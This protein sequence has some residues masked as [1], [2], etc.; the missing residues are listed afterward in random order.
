MSKFSIYTIFL[1]I[2][3]I[4][5]VYPFSKPSNDFASK[6]ALEA[7]KAFDFWNYMRSY[8]SGI[9]RND[10]WEK[11]FYDNKNSESTSRLSANW[12]AIGPKNIG[13]RTLC[14][15]VHPLDSNIIY[16][17]SASGGLWKSTSGG[18]GAQ[19]W[20]YVPTG[21]PVLGVASI[22]INPQNPNEM[23][24]GTGEV[25]NLEN[26]T[27]NIVFRTTRGSYGIGILK[28]NDGGNTW[29][30]VLDWSS[31][32]M[33]GV[34]DLII[35]PSNPSTIYAAT[36]NGLYKSTNSGNSWNLI[37]D[38]L[39][40]VDLLLSPQDTN[41]I[42]VTHGSLDN[43][44]ESGI[45]KSTNGGVNF[46]KLNTGVISF[47][48]KAKL[49]V[50]L[51][52]PTTIYA[53]IA[54]AFVVQGLY[55]S[56]DN[57]VTWFAISTLNI[58]SYQGWYSHDVAISHDGSDI[59]W[60]GIDV[61]KS[62]SDLIDFNQSSYWFGW[63]IDQTPLAGED[64]GEDD[65]VHSD[66]HQI[67][68]DNNNPNKIYFATDGGLFI[69]YDN[70]LTFK[71]RNGGY[72]TQQFY[73]KFSNSSQDPSLSIGGMQDNATA[74]YTGNLSWRRLI[75]GDGASTFI[76]PENDFNIYA[77]TQYG[78]I[79]KSYDRG[80]SFFDQ[81]NVPTAGNET[82]AF[83]APYT[84]S[85]NIPHTFYFGARKI[86]HSIDNGNSW[87]ESTLFFA[88]N[89]VAACIEVSPNNSN[90]LYVSTCSEDYTHPPKI[91]KSDDFGVN[92]QEVTGLPDRVAMDIAI[93]PETDDIAYIVFGGFGTQHLYKTENQGQTWQ[94]I[95]QGLPDVPTY[96][97]LIDPLYPNIIYVGNEIGV[98][99]SI[100]EGNTF[101][102]YDGYTPDALLAMDLTIT[103]DRKLRLATY[104]NG[105]W[106]ADMI[107]SPN[108][109]GENEK[110]DFN[111]YPNPFS[112]NLYIKIA[113]KRADSY[114]I[115]DNNGKK[116]DV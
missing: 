31:N 68:Y 2:I 63:Y 17:G 1:V 61:H 65:Y 112:N 98:F 115:Y 9:I 40:A 86:H 26:S 46:T 54:D 58:P 15:A 18:L 69:T 39:M 11:A 37:H 6:E 81:L 94:T 97:V 114:A 106:D 109:I 92:I 84:R 28:T 99:A 73:A 80:E 104:G 23:Y 38:K 36:T 56:T 60:G 87:I 105:V 78:N 102:K 16:L 79:L 70:G 113:D 66:I 108:A 14:V 33:K 35:N 55:K 116:I 44:S 111:V 29:S 5:C 71:G 107:V 96:S 103:A 43:D 20:Q 57:G 83:V 59:F 64:E 95:G 24:I 8:P 72:Q 25:Y 76:D 88:N 100:D 85:I 82:I 45:Y 53:S 41:T 51:A 30:K 77:T 3:S 48:G 101:T 93:H 21:F 91:Y 13:G 75:G 4:I 12:Q 52:H 22:A 34:Q 67:L 90:F 89:N 47:S 50:D 10:V 27:P 32:E 62:K 42:F 49:A 19:A 74:R 7:G 110:I